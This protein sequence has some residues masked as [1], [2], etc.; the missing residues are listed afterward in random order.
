ML[1]GADREYADLSVTNTTFK[2]LTISSE[3][4]IC[5][6]HVFSRPAKPTATN[7]LNRKTGKRGLTS[8]APFSLAKSHCHV[9][10]NWCVVYLLMLMQ[11]F[12]SK[13]EFT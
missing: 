7:G 13:Y 2:F 3:Y 4:F 11:F 1:E 9:S 6:Y 5:N 10:D 12:P 8:C